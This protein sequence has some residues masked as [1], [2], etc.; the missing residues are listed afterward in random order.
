MTFCSDDS[1]VNVHIRNYDHFT[2]QLG[3]EMYTLAPMAMINTA[4]FLG[5][6]YFFLMERN[7]IIDS[8]MKSNY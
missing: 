7:C 2:R 4:L 1:V 3:Q 5:E 6:R 8:K